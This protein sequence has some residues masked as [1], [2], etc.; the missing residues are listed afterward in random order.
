[1]TSQGSGTAQSGAGSEGAER[2]R[3]EPKGAEGLRKEPKGAER[4]A[5]RA[6]GALLWQRGGPGRSGPGRGRVNGGGSRSP[7]APS[8]KPGAM[9][10]KEYH[11][12]LPM[13][14]EEYQVAQLYMIQVRLE[15]E[16]RP[17][18]VA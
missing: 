2:S 11:I 9:L 7:L 18:A 3:R 5:E 13:S 1:M 17:E 8:P 14:L 6:G 4:A 16:P 15:P 10:I 12:L